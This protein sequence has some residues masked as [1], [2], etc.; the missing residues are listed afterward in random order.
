MQAPACRARAECPGASDGA[1]VPDTR[2]R[3]RRRQP[4]PQTEVE[5]WRA[6]LWARALAAQG[7]GGAGAQR[8]ELGRS[9]QARFRNS[10]IERFRFLPAVE[11]LLRTLRARGLVTV[12]ITNGHPD[13]QAAKVEA[14][15]ARGLVDAV[16]IGGEE[17]AAGRHEKPHPSI[18]ARHAG[19]GMVGVCFEPLLPLLVVKLGGGGG[20]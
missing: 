5:E 10:R 20:G 9:L 6:G 17:V 12:I 2:A 18:F 14:C 13:V 3:S 19:G 1:G 7:R 11:E 8:A 15:G 4:P 16:L